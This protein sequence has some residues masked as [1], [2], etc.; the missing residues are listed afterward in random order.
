M[1]HRSHPFLLAL[2]IHGRA[3]YW[4]LMNH[5]SS[6]LHYIWSSWLQNMNL[7]WTE[8]AAGQRFAISCRTRDRNARLLNAAGNMM[9]SWPAISRPD[10]DRLLQKPLWSIIN[11]SW[12]NKWPPL[13]WAEQPFPIKMRPW[14]MFRPVP[15]RIDKYRHDG[16]SIFIKTW[17]MN[18]DRR[19]NIYDIRNWFSI[20]SSRESA[21]DR[22]NKTYS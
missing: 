4:T 10:D 14:M 19:Y 8:Q 18:N 6:L 12:S 5:L 22:V 1:L 20:T 15:K 9:D 2:A 21:S 16:D 11:S 7:H 3:W 17:Q 13:T